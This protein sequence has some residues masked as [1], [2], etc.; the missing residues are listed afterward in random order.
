MLDALGRRL[1]FAPPQPKPGFIKITERDTL[2]FEAIN[3]HGP[4]P[5]HYLYEFTRSAGKN[6]VHLKRKISKLTH[7]TTTDAPYLYRPEQQWASIDGKFQPNIYDLTPRALAVLAERGIRLNNRTDPFLHRLMG[8]CVNASIHLAAEK[9]GYA[10]A[11][12][13][14]LL[15]HEKCPEVTRRSPNPIAM[16][17]RDKCVVPDA[18]FGVQKDRPCFYAFEI[19]RRTESINSDTA[20]TAYGR[21]LIGYIDILENRTYRAQFG[22]P[23]FKILTV[24]TNVLHLQHM[25]NFYRSLNAPGYAKHFLFKSVSNF[26]SNWRV[27]PVMHDL[28][29]EPWTAADGSQLQIGE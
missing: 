6:L 29:D 28:F 24:T 2:V 10:Y 9:K 26:G 19:D 14:R 1:R 7:G 18:I 16:P 20:K 15:A 13:A 5:V 11:D 12:L 27:P 3:R 17:A 4:L 23:N 22:I 25:L 21:K 8:A